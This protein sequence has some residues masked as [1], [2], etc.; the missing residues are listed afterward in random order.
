MS[1]TSKK[2]SPGA[3]GGKVKKKKYIRKN[4][5]LSGMPRSH[6]AAPEGLMHYLVGVTDKLRGISAEQRDKIGGVLP[7]GL[8]KTKHVFPNHGDTISSSKRKASEVSKN[9]IKGYKKGSPVKFTPKPEKPLSPAA[10]RKQIKKQSK[11][12]GGKIKNRNMGGVIGGGLASQDV[13]D[14][15]YKYDS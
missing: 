10:K 5:R 15:L 7:K 12:Y 1:E 13:T 2:R 9:I 3:L 14:Y 11:K 8:K 6:A 4:N